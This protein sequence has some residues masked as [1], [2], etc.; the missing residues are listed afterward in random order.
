MTQKNQVFIVNV[1]S[2]D[3]MRQMMT[4][5]VISQPT[6]VIAKL[7]IITKIRRYKRFH[8]GHHFILMAIKMHNAHDMDRFIKKCAHL[9]HRKQSKNYLSF[10]FF[11][12]QFFKQCVNI[13]F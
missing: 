9:F 10:F 6:N 3:L 2:I 8:E 5:S 11:C 13:V 1:I 4:L 12:I 7:N